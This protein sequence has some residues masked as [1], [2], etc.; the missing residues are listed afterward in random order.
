MIRKIASFLPSIV[1]PIAIN[2]VLILI[3]ARL[4]SP[5]EYGEYS[6]YISS[7]GVLYALTAGFLQAAAFRFYSM[8]GAYSDHAEYLSTFVLANVGICLLVCLSL[9]VSS[10]LF[11]FDWMVISFAIILTA[12]YQFYLNWYRL[13]DSARGFAFGRLSAAFGALA[14]ILVWMALFGEADFVVPIYTFYGAYLLLI[15]VG[16][17]SVL[18]KIS[19]RS[20]SWD[21][22]VRAFKYGMPMSGVSV[23]SLLIPYGAQFAIL[24]YLSQSD[25]GAYSLSFRLSDATLAN[26]S[27][28]ILTVM[29]P[30]VMRAYDSDK[31]GTGGSSA[32]LLTKVISLNSWVT[33][34][35]AFAF[36]VVAH[37]LI[38]IIFPAYIGA[39]SVLIWIVFA[40]A[41]RS[42]SM[43]TV[44]GLELAGA[45]RL[46][47]VLSVAAAA[48]NILYMIIFLPVY[49]LSSAA[50]A[51]FFSYLLLNIMLVVA[52]RKGARV[53][54]DFVY[55]GKVI[56][57]SI[58][59]AL[60]AFAWSLFLPVHD[61][62]GLFLN[63]AVFG[64]VYVVLSLALRLQRG[65]T[66]TF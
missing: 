21:L 40:S 26:V 51:S 4:L 35:I 8:K 2:F 15:V 6:I 60:S 28:I 53:V 43:I 65:F 64:A 27:M 5:A 13:R 20:F 45:T 1:I 46:L 7:I 3:Y 34:P 55:I 54:L 24:F 10:F 48:V 37:P 17:L 18:R 61:V 62:V 19:L 36:A 52:S 63:V 38:S 44:K 41:L 56:G 23:V 57:V 30:A 33:I 9:F 59:A 50:H 12:L 22:L 39:E 66:V 58:I 25:V 14:A 42:L 32:I 29:T 11:E 16:L 49:G 47:F 31:G